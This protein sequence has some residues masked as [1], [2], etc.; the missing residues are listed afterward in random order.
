MDR[1]VILLHISLMHWDQLPSSL[2]RVGRSALHQCEKSW[3]WKDPAIKDFNLWIVLG[4]EGWIFVGG[5]ERS[6]VARG[7]GLLFRP[8]D[9]VSGGHNPAKPLRVFSLH[10]QIEPRMK[11]ALCRVVPQRLRFHDPVRIDGEVAAMLTLPEKEKP[12]SRG[13]ARIHLTT[14]L[15]L[16]A[17]NAVTVAPDPVDLKLRQLAQ[18]MAA[19]PGQNWTAGPSARKAGLSLSHFNRRFR[20]VAGESLARHVIVRR[21]DRARKLLRE[22]PLSLSEIAEALGYAD[23]FYFQRQFRAETGTTPGR[24]RR[25]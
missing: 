21:M 7:D 18:D 15:A 14:L 6:A 16:A 10:F 22:T 9:S 11:T 13:L 17:H 4:G 25:G 3:S 23:I 1:C 12:W 20:R 8:G 19:R 5:G 2:S 24:Y